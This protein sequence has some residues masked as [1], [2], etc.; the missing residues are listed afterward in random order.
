LGTVLQFSN[1]EL[2]SVKELE[3]EQGRDTFRPSASQ[4]SELGET[5]VEDF[6]DSIAPRDVFRLDVAVNDARFVRS[7]ESRGN[8][9][10]ILNKAL[11][12]KKRIRNCSNTAI[13]QV[14]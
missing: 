7:G 13:R 8:L 4:E 6:A 11:A 10:G 5:E 9:N 1:S 12:G 14:T 3:N 2:Q